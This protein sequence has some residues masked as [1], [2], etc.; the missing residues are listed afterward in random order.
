MIQFVDDIPA[1]E[2]LDEIGMSQ[3]TETFKVNFANG[4]NFISRRRLGQ[5]RLQDYPK[6]NITNYGDE[7]IL[8]KF[9]THILKHPY[10]KKIRPSPAKK[11]PTVNLPSAAEPKRRL[12]SQDSYGVFERQESFGNNVDRNEKSSDRKEGSGERAVPVLERKDSKQIKTRQRHSFDDKA[13]EAINKSRGIQVEVR[14][15]I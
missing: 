11:L 5:L 14:I 8:H 2:W 1:D 6:L 10:I 7:K 13:W 4:G 9:I 12:V 3:Y 15:Y